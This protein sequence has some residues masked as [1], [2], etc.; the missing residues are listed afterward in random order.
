MSL[1]L[2]ACGTANAADGAP[3]RGA[4]VWRESFHENFA[5]DLSNAEA[6][7]VAGE[8]DELTRMVGPLVGQRP[9][10]T[11]HSIWVAVDHCLTATTQGALAR[12]IVYG[13]W[14]SDEPALAEVWETA[15]ERLSSCVAA[16]GGWQALGS[17]TALMATCGRAEVVAP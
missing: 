9:D 5:V 14:S 12:A 8:V 13:G 16:A 3:S 7:C 17:Y 4:T 10:D 15:D 11:A 2:A 6:D 1:T